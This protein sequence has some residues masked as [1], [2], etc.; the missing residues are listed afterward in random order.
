MECIAEIC[1]ALPVAR[2]PSSENVQGADEAHS[3]HVRLRNI[4]RYIGVGGLGSLSLLNLNSA[5]KVLGSTFLVQEYMEGGNL[6]SQVLEQVW[7]P[8]AQLRF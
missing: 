1:W 3:W 4:V 6:R 5:R 8:S 2:R 7:P